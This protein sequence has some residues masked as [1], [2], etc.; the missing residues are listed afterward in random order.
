MEFMTKGKPKENKL[1][2]YGFQKRGNEYIYETL[3]HNSEFRAMITVCNEKLFGTVIEMDTNEEYLGLNVGTG[4]FGIQ[5]KNEFQKIVDD[6]FEHCFENEIYI[7]PQTKRIVE[8]VFQKYQVK[9]EFLWEKYPNYGVFRNHFNQKW[10]GIIMNVPYEKIDSNKQG[11]VEILNVRVD[12][13]E[14][15]GIYE[16]YHMNK[17]YWISILLDDTLKDEEILTYIEKSYQSVEKRKK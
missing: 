16:A 10:F 7:F 14:K 5:I 2:S 8:K 17:K 1:I 3:F 11:E 6:I 15:E 9:L 12:F 4:S 13:F